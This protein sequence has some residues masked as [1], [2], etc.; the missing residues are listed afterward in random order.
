MSRCSMEHWVSMGDCVRNSMD[1][2]S[3]MVDRGMD[4]R[5]SM[6]DS[7][8]F[9]DIRM[10]FSLISDISNEPVVMISVVRDNLYTTI[11][12]LHTVLTFHNSMLILA[13]CLG[14]VSA[15][16]ISTTILICKRLRGELLLMVWSWVWS[17]VV[18]SRSWVVRS[19]DCRCTQG[20][21]K[22]EGNNKDLHAAV[23]KSDQE[24]PC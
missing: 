8:R 23:S 20:R 2:G 13:L 14:K 11:R 7:M 24:L 1:R 4:N 17:W 22:E 9:W 5:G 10:S 15:I 6:V 18:G 16:S 12:E 19:R 3:S 21:A